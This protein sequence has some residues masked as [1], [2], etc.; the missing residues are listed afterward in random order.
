ME[1]TREIS[2]KVFR[3]NPT[4]GDTEG[5][6]E[7][8]TVPILEQGTSVMNVLQYIS[9]HYDGGLAYYASCRRG[10]C[11]GCTVRVN[12]KPKLACLEIV[13]GDLILEPVAKG[14]VVKDLLTMPTRSEQ[15]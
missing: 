1:N 7:S 10:E 6:Y 8:Y 13:E 11:A 15:T 2:V 12:G 9:E 5:R 14:K 3:F 4:R